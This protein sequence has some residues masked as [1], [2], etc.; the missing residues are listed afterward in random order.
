M[1]YLSVNDILALYTRIFKELG[2]KIGLRD[3]SLLESAIDKPRASFGGVDLYEGGLLKA[4]VLCGRN[5]SLSGITFN[6][7]VSE[8]CQKIIT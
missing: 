7:L 3:I 4:V 6:L 8:K 1:R 2:G 5:P